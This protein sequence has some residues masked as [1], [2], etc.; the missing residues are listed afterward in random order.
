MVGSVVSGIF[1]A[2]GAKMGADAQ[3]DAAREAAATQRYMYDTT[4]ADFAP[5]R[6]AGGL[7]LSRLA[8]TYGLGGY[9]DLGT[10]NNLS[11][12]GGGAAPAGAPGAPGGGTAGAPTPQA[13]G[14]A[15]AQSVPLTPAAYGI[16]DEGGVTMSQILGSGFQPAGVN[17]SGA[18]LVS[19]QQVAGA[20][21]ANTLPGGAGG[22]T[23]DPGQSLA[24]TAQ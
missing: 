1:G 21:G 9:G 16:G 14:G 11:A 18:L 3:V 24:D 15:L 19:P 2:V 23:L 8:N 22:D 10:F 5:Y 6:M 12:M 20:G 7:A 17:N 13:P 4:R